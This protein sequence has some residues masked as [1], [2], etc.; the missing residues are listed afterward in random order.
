[1][2]FFIAA[3]TDLDNMEVSKLAVTNDSPVKAV[4]LVGRS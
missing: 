4:S 2:V 3:R 1:M